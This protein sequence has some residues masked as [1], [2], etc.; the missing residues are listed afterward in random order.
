MERIKIRLSSWYWG[1]YVWSDSRDAKRN[2][3]AV[4]KTAH[5]HTFEE[6]IEAE[7]GWH[8]SEE[9]ANGQLTPCIKE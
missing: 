8:H 5:G 1:N 9:Y 4:G 2:G 7:H 6:Y 3:W